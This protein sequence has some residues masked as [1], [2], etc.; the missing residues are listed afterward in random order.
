MNATDYIVDLALIGVVFRQMRTRPLTL[1]SV[2][3]PVVIMAIAGSQYL[4]G[5]P[6]AGNDLLLTAIFVVIGLVLGTTSGLTTRVWRNESGVTVAKAG[7]AAALLWI[8][9]MGFRFG[10]SIWANTNSGAKSLTTF[11]FHHSITSAQAWTTALVLMAFAEVLSRVGYLQY[12]RLQA[13][14]VPVLSPRATRLG[15]D[16]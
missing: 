7:V 4:R 16:S 14:R 8:V 2:L 12:R 3:F 13:D 5:F 9:G 15:A 11:S 10:F 6:T 1:K